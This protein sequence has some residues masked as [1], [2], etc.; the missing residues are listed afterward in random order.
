MSPGLWDRAKPVRCPVWPGTAN[1]STP[2]S[3]TPCAFWARRRAAPSPGPARRSASSTTPIPPFY[4]WFP[5]GEL[6]TCANAL[7]RHVDDGP[8][9]PGRADL[10]LPGHRHQAHLHLPRTARR[11]RALRR[12]AARPRRRARAT[13]SSS[14]CRWC[15]RP[16]SRCWPARG[17]ARCTRWC[18]AGSPP[19]EL[20]AR[21][22]DARP[23]VVVSA[24]CGIEPTRI[25]DY[26]PMLDAALDI[27][28]HDTPACVDPAAR[29]AARAS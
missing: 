12:R 15:P 16:S 11:D 27:A 17:S 24:S 6:N 29:A 5:D 2:A 3:T 10:R 7:D 25:V 4:R 9:R 22:D 19:H 18:S 20:A 21:I 26:K 28:E 1:C 13:A 23:A 14:T 8:R